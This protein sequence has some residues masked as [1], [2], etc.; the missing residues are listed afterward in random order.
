MGESEK[1]LDISRRLYS[2]ILV[3]LLT[4]D[5]CPDPDGV[6]LLRSLILL[7][8]GCNKIAVS[9]GFVAVSIPVVDVLSSMLPIVLIVRAEG[10]WDQY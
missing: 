1:M 5:D 3:L 2:H 4:D 7:G 10:D 8:I 9:R 6:A